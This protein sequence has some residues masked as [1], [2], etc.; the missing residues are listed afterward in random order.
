MN[1]R[2]GDTPIIGGGTFADDKIAGI[3]ATGFGESIMRANL[4][5]R[6]AHLIQTG[7]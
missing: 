6:V 4:S 2:V 5:S 7:K 3:S 1:G